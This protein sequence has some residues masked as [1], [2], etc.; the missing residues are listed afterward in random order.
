V[1]ERED[2]VEC[3]KWVLRVL[4]VSDHCRW[5]KSVK[6][7]GMVTSYPFLHETFFIGLGETQEIHSQRTMEDFK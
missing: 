3:K 5:S 1:E 6:G 7:K 4:N 2:D